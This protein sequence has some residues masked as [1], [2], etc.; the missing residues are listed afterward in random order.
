MEG[1]QG[2]VLAPAGSPPN[3]IAQVQARFREL[4]GGFRA[5][6]ARQSMPVEA[7]V[8]TATSA[9]QG[10]AI[11]GLM[12]TLTS[13]LTSAFPAPPPQAAAEI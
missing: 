5:W 1:R 4:E 12:G 11:G 6:L 8:V 13:D 9:A 3:P 10:A 7:A 2:L